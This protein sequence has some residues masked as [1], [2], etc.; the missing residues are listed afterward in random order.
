[1]AE[2]PP[3]SSVST[4]RGATL[5]EEALADLT[6]EL[7]DAN[8]AGRTVD[9]ARLVEKYGVD[10][11][12]VRRCLAV[13]RLLDDAVEFD[14][15]DI[16]PPRLPADY[17]ILGE[18]G[19][20]GM[21][22]VYR[23]LQTSLDR[24]VAV[25]VLR[26]GE[27]IFGEAIRR[28]QKEAKSLARL[29][30]PHIVSV[31]DV[32]QAGGN[33]FYTMD[34][35]DGEPL[36]TLIDN[37][38]VGPAR[39]VRLL[40]QVASAIAYTHAHGIIHRDLKPSNILVDRQDNAYVVDFGLARDMG[41]AGRV[42]LKLT[43]SGRVIGTP[44]YMSPEQAR[45]DSATVG[46]PTDI[47]SLGAVL[48]ECLVGRPPFSGASLVE[49]LYSVIHVEPVAPRTV[50]PAISVDLEAIC[51]KAISKSPSDRHESAQAFLEDLES[52]SKDRG[53][54]APGV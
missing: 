39:A 29:R 25:K 15:E 1:M 9:F 3:G 32:G 10:K 36:D 38:K 16:P 20:G 18:I 46:E 2:A 27:L 31:H 50:V 28:F 37:G 24:E 47:Y 51:L 5:Q 34:L 19:R 23:A 6:E 4:G 30:H 26:P 52:L 12:E 14:R 40:E 22:V 48:Y 53:G 49:T 33:V 21:G 7:Q 17:K 43:R 54:D 45:G 44:A 42:S 41:L 35:I 13:I 8:S 11:E